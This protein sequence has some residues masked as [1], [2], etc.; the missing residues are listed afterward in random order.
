MCEVITTN[1]VNLN[2]EMSKHTHQYK[3]DPEMIKKGHKLFE[4]T[5]ERNNNVNINITLQR[6]MAHNTYGEHNE[7]AKNM[8]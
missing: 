3:K 6:E 8:S 7:Y 1:Q 2:N 5:Q 4:E